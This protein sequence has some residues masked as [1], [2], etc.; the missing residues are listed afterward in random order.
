VSLDGHAC[1]GDTGRLLTDCSQAADGDWSSKV[2]W[3]TDQ[4]G[5]FTVLIE[6]SY[7]TPE[8]IE[9]AT[10]GF[11]AYHR[12]QGGALMPSPM[13][14]SYQSGSTWIELYVLDDQ[15]HVGESFT[16]SLALPMDAFSEDQ[17]AIRISI[18]YSSHVVGGAL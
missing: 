13:S 12:N 4:T 14:I 3:N 17:L 1:S 8:S 2:S 9:G 11:K 16:E 6:M 7:S 18:R 15:E 5:D 10:W